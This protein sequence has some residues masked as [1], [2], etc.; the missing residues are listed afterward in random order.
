MI[1]IKQAEKYGFV[2]PQGR[3]WITQDSMPRLARDA[4]L[5]TRANGGI[6]AELAAYID[7]EVIEILTAPRKARALYDETK[8]GDWSTPYAKFRVNELTGS[9]AAYSD[10]GQ[11]GMSG[12]NYEF[13]TREQYLFQ[14]II[15]Y[16]DLEAAAGNAAKINMASEKQRA[17]A[18]T[19][20]MDANKFALLG[21]K[22]REIYGALN[23]PNLPAPITPLTGA[24]GLTWDKKST[25]EIY[26]DVRMLFTEL[27][28]QTQGWVDENT[29]L[30]LALSPAMSVHLGK[31]TDFNV[32]VLDMLKKYF[33]NLTIV[34]LPE[35]AGQDSGEVMQ[36]IATEVR[37]MKTGSLGYSEKM[38]AGRVVSELS[39]LSQ[40]FT[41]G[42][43]GCIIKLPFAVAQMR[44]M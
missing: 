31:S 42:T 29:P 32:S 34:T 4:N 28:R 39:S 16:G 30:K 23:D 14:T 24:A 1:S 13:V 43:W 41:A 36:L 37:G 25:T 6:P 18:N 38:R 7:P 22:G 5:V 9:S 17:A 12:V 40:K 15:Q 10:Y 8:T 11:S 27:V 19:L 3:D 35:L 20:D 26:E 33:T 21:V 2:F 44:G